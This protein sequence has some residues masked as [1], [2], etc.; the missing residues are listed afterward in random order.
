MKVAFVNLQLSG[1]LT[2]VTRAISGQAR[3]CVEAGVP[4][5]FWVVNPG[6]RGEEGGLH[7]AQFEESR[8]GARATRFFKARLLKQV[9]ELEAYDVIILRYPLAIDLD[10]LAFVEGTRAKII[11]V[12]H[13]R[14]IDELLSAGRT[15]GAMARALIEQVNGARVL[16]RVAG[17]AAVTDEIRRYELQRAGTV[18]PSTVVANGIDVERVP[19]TGFVPFDG[20]ELRMLFIASSHAPWHGTDRL[21][22]SLRSYRGPV[23]LRLEMIGGASG[24]SPGTTEREGPLT[25]HHHGTLTGAPL[26]A[27]FRTA[28]VAFSSLAMFRT[29]LREACVLKTREYVARGMPFVYGYDDVDLLEPQPFCLGVG[30]SDSAF[31]VDRIIDFAKACAER[32]GLSDEMRAFAK[33][34]LDWKVKMQAFWDFANEVSR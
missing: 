30:N 34:R 9:R 15:A 2:G 10:P 13:T 1:E 16:R 3:A 6:K 8:L 11:T 27:V 4:I 25:I 33:A 7:F 22:A 14:E 18:R 12:H 17:I 31:P 20:R 5:D 19:Q 32:R 23:Q 21:L 28:N 24:A 26:D 29:G